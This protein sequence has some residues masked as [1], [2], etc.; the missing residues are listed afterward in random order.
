RTL[1]PSVRSWRTRGRW[2]TS[3]P[4]WAR[5]FDDAMEVP[6]LT[7]EVASRPEAG[8]ILISPQRCAQIVWLVS[9]GDSQDALPAGYDNV[10]RKLRLRVADVVTE[11]GATE[12]DILQNVRFARGPSSDNGHV[13]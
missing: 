13:L 1:A 3:S 10:P 8:D 7:I 5:R 4:Q 9:I 2:R 12:A 6:N 11:E